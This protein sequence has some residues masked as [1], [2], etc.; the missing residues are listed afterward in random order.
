MVFEIIATVLLA[1]IVFSVQQ[2]NADVIR[3]QYRSLSILDTQPGATTKYTVSYRHN[4]LATTGSVRMLFC[5]D[6]IP[7][8]AC[9]PP[10]GLDVSG[11]V[12]SSQ[13]GETGYS[14]TTR[15]SNELVLSRPP[16]MVDNDPSSYVFDNIINPTYDEH[17]YA[18]RLSTHAS[19]D[20]TGPVI[21]LGSVVNI[22]NDAVGLAAQVPPILVF[23]L[24]QEVSQ[25]C[26][27]S[28][29]ANFTD[30]GDLIP[31]STALARSQMAAGTNASDGFAIAAYGT[32]MLA[33]GSEIPALSQPTESRP[34]TNQFGINLVENTT[35]IH[36]ANPDNTADAALPT[37]DY[38]QSNR[39][40]FRNGD[41][42]A[43]SP[44]VALTS[45]FTVS[46]LVNVSNALPA[47]VYTTTITYICSGRF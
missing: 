47:G 31:G 8:H 19:S 36:G 35:P 15:T 10:A 26:F 38:A 41:V 25:D 27:D 4:S 24:A 9:V 33:G 43:Q 11:A 7:H 14:I 16:S 42:V 13:T 18:I 12:L 20:A 5:I 40:T 3:L 22:V 6:P 23:C 1:V 30:M 45:R 32:S 39:F 28:D 37:P 46:Y 2:V 34:G 29:G 44:G 21:D 17:S